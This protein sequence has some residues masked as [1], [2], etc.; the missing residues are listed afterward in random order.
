[1]ICAI[2][3]LSCLLTGCGSDNITD[4]E[5]EVDDIVGVEGER[6]PEEPSSEKSIEENVLNEE[7]GTVQEELQEGDIR[8]KGKY[9]GWI[10]G[11]VSNEESDDNSDVLLINPETKEIEVYTTL[12]GVY[13]TQ[14][15]AVSPDGSKVAYTQW[16]DEE[17]TRKGVCIMVSDAENNVLGKYFSDNGYNPLITAISWMPDNETL[18]FNISIED[19]P[20]YSDAICLFNMKTEQLQVIDQGRVWRGNEVIDGE[21]DIEFPALSQ[22]ELNELIDKYGG[23][24]HIPVEENGSY[25]YVEIGAP[26]LSPDQTKIAYMTNFCRNMAFLL[27]EKNRRQCYVWLPVF[28]LPM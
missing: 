15:C 14:T 9:S 28:L 12:Q 4:V 23:N 2:I 1:M 27:W 22:K 21:R 26:I 16:A 19:Q 5:K 13:Q 6:L 10:C 8:I 3:S 20:Y 17:D 18:L 7:M 25:N 11:L 24:V